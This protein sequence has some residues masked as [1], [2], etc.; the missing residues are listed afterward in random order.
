VIG[1]LQM[2]SDGWWASVESVWQVEHAFKIG[3]KDEGGVLAMDGAAGVYRVIAS[4][5]GPPSIYVL[6]AIGAP[7]K[8]SR[9]LDGDRSVES[10]M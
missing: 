3:S 5:V 1:H 4:S 8:A 10:P 7:V 6:C 9:G 2:D